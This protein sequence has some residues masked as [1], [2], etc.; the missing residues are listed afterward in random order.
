MLPLYGFAD[1]QNKCVENRWLG[2]R[3]L[4]KEIFSSTL[5]EKKTHPRKHFFSIYDLRSAQ[6]AAT[7]LK[8]HF[9][10]KIMEG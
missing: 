10:S 9:G 7:L 5:R 4:K 8:T 2:N 3:R 6:S 1:T